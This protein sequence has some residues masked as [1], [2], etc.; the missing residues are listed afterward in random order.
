M[1][2]TPDNSQAAAVASSDLVRQLRAQA[3]DLRCAQSLKVYADR[4]DAAANELEAYRE[5]GIPSA[6]GGSSPSVEKLRQLATSAWIEAESVGVDAE[7]SGKVPKEMM[8]LKAR[9]LLR[10]VLHV[11][12]TTPPNDQAGPQ[13]PITKDKR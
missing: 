10:D 1:I 12:N 6:P 9:D 7:R 13:P 2:S 5:G 3:E 4:C 11:L 8:V